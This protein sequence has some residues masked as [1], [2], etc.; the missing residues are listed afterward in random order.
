[1]MASQTRLHILYNKGK[2]VFEINR[3]FGEQVV[4]M[5]KV[6][7]YEDVVLSKDMFGNNRMVCAIKA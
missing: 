6:M 5:L 7:G 4:E 3:R 1:M 2:L